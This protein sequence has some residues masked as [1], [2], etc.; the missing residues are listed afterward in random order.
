MEDVLDNQTSSIL[1]IHAATILFP[2]K[3]NAYWKQQCILYKRCLSTMV[4]QLICNQQVVGSN[5]TGSLK[6]HTAKKHHVS[7]VQ[8]PSVPPHGTVAQTVEQWPE[9]VRMCLG[10]DMCSNMLA[11]AYPLLFACDVLYVSAQAV[12]KTYACLVN[13]M[14]WSSNGCSADCKS[15]A[16]GV[17]GSNPSH[18]I[19]DVYC[20]IFTK[21]PR[22]YWFDSSQSQLRDCSSKW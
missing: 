15:V 14:Q 22:G 9:R 2:P 21:Y 8:L 17:G 4:V 5:P 19:K 12:L 3:I 18:C 10:K 13:C 20:M 11:E 7:W 1:K 16:F 6:A